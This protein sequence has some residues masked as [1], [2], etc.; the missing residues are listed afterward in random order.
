[1]EKNNLDK[2][3]IVKAF[4]KHAELLK[5]I[6]TV[7]HTQLCISPEG[8]EVEEWQERKKELI[9]M[10]RKMMGLYGFAADL[11]AN[12]VG[13]D[14]H[15]SIS[16][17]SNIQCSFQRI[18]ILIDSVYEQPF[19]ELY[20][21]SLS[22]I[23]DK[24]GEAIDVFHRMLVDYPE[25]PSSIEEGTEQIAKIER[26]VDEENIIISRQISVVTNGDAGFVCYIMRKVVREL[27][28]ITDYLKACA[29][30]INEM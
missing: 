12:E 24:V 8:G 20:M 3:G 5:E 1:M 10:L 11:P 22:A 18:V 27:E 28:H 2:K 21:D 25:N 23:S 29:E 17:M 4:T 9:K 14:A 15:V 6:T 19:E 16:S 26:A 30:S 13:L 7:L